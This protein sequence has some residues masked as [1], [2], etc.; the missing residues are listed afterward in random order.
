[1]GGGVHT[2]PACTSTAPPA[3]DTKRAHSSRPRQLRAECCSERTRES[4]AEV[5]L[6]G[7]VCGPQPRAWGREPVRPGPHRTNCERCRRRALGRPRLAAR[8]RWWRSS[9]P[10]ARGWLRRLRPTFPG[11]SYVSQSFKRGRKETTCYRRRGD[12]PG[13]SCRSGLGAPV[14]A[15]RGGDRPS[16]PALPAAATPAPPPPCPT[17]AAP[18]ATGKGKGEGEGE[19][20]AASASRA[21][22]TAALS[23][24]TTSN[25]G[26]RAAGSAF[27]QLRMSGT[28]VPASGHCPD[29]TVGRSP[30]ATLCISTNGDA[31]AATPRGGGGVC[32]HAQ[33][34]NHAYMQR[35]AARKQHTHTRST[36]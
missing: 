29:G 22:A 11:V 17:P 4:A 20:E 6:Q 28:S 26:G 7:G 5:G 1:M 10:R 25:M 34:H 16:A 18:H 14:A 33:T 2:R 3:W 19:A 9:G 35:T 31:S 8:P 32:A 24:D 36:H 23:A 21:A 30:P 27:Q 12:A 15:A 13:R